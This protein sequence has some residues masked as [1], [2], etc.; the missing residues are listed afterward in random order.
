MSAYVCPLSPNTS[1]PSSIPPGRFQLFSTTPIAPPSNSMIVTASSSPSVRAPCTCVESCAYTLFTF[2]L[3]RNHQQNAMPW[4]AEVHQRAAPRLVDVPEPVGVRPGVLLPLLHEMD[5]PERPLVG[6]LL[7]LHVLRRE[8][9]LLRVE[10]QHAGLGAGVDHRVRFLERHAERLLAHDVL[11][12]ARRVDRDLRVHPVRRGDGDQLDLRIA[13]QR[14]DSRRSVWRCRAAWRTPR[15]FLA[16]VRRR[17]RLPPRRASCAPT[18]RCSPPGMN[19]PLIFTLFIA[20]APRPFRAPTI[21]AASASNVPVHCLVAQR[22][23]VRRQ[24]EDHVR[25]AGIQGEVA[26][27]TPAAWSRRRPSTCPLAVLFQQHTATRA[28][29][30]RTSTRF[31]PCSTRCGVSQ[32]IRTTRPSTT[33]AAR[34]RCPR[35]TSSID[36]PAECSGSM[37]SRTSRVGARAMVRRAT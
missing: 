9:Q 34:S 14:V 16:S 21:A 13:Q 22:T 27:T 17:R 8:E 11:P 32:S 12:R 4:T 2:G 24:R 15:S 35:T 25:R 7:R 28:A 6:H 18:R 1:M 19:D 37:P 23:I 20:L 10:Q 3:P 5:A 33:R 31:G 36:T 30:S 26:R 29:S